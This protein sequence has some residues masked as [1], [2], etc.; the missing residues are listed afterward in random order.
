M[1]QEHLTDKEKATVSQEPRSDIKGTVKD[2]VFCDLFKDRR[3]ALQIYQAI[4]PEDV[5]VTESDIGNVTI[6]NITTLKPSCTRCFM[7]IVRLLKNCFL[8]IPI[9]ILMKKVWINSVKSWWVF[10][11]A[12]GNLAW[13]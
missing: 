8:I 6:D 13:I 5:D 7:P 9:R 4:H 11:E 12:D 10:L 2:S 3:Y 1:E